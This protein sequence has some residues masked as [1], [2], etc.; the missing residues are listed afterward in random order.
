MDGTG[1]EGTP[2]IMNFLTMNITAVHA[3]QHQT[4]FIG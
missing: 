1:G 2:F 4:L 3:F